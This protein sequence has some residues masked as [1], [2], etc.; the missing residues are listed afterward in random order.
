[1]TELKI[2]DKTDVTIYDS[3]VNIFRDSIK[4]ERSIN[5]PISVI[6]WSVLHKDLIDS[7]KPDFAKSGNLLTGIGNWRVIKSLFRSKLYAG[8]AIFSDDGVR[9]GYVYT[10]FIM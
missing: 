5:V 9:D 1:M 10:L 7:L 8:F 3:Y 4:G 2:S 6:K